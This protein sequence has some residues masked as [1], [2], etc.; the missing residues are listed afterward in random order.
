MLC[1]PPWSLKGWIGS[2]EL[3]ARAWRVAVDR[4]RTNREGWK[5]RK[6]HHPLDFSAISS[7]T[8]RPSLQLWTETRHN[9]GRVEL[10]VW[11]GIR[12]GVSHGMTRTTRRAATTGRLSRHRTDVRRGVGRQHSSVFP[13]T[14]LRSGV[15]ADSAGLELMASSHLARERPGT[16][17]VCCSLGIFCF[18]KDQNKPGT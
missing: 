8:R 18:S 5:Q 12:S 2:G 4:G 10:E 16:V 11:H 7:E 6:R 17:S 14:I 13:W 15:G 1:I 3:R 9:I